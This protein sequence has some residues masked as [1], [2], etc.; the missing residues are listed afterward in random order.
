VG[1]TPLA[2]P[3]APRFPRPTW[4]RLDQDQGGTRPGDSPG[5][6]MGRAQIPKARPPR[7][8]FVAVAASHRSLRW[9]RNSDEQ[10]SSNFRHNDRGRTETK[11]MLAGSVHAVSRVAVRPVGSSVRRSTMA[12]A[13]RSVVLG[14]FLSPTSRR[15][16][17][18]ARKGPARLCDPR[19]YI[20]HFTPAHLLPDL[21]RRAHPRW[22]VGDVQWALV[23]ASRGPGIVPVSVQATDRRGWCAY[24]SQ[25]SAPGIA[26]RIPKSVRARGFRSSTDPR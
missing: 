8:V 3:L 24:F 1:P 2:G 5:P 11:M 13:R 10:F 21:P 26:R 22:V 17:P 23:S 9:S 15:P 7:P 16:C 12:T 6:S 25:Y 20:H 19:D 4:V 14:E 18:S